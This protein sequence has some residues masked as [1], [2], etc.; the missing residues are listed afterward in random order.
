MAFRN[1]TDIGVPIKILH[2]SEGHII[3]LETIIKDIIEGK[4]EQ[5]EDNM[6]CH[7]STVTI[8]KKNGDVRKMDNLYICGSQIKMVI[9]PEALQ[10]GLFSARFPIFRNKDAVRCMVFLRHGRGK[11]GFYC[12]KG[13]T[14]FF[15]RTQYI[16]VKFVK[17]LHLIFVTHVDEVSK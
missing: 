10:V 8:K 4:L 9:L 3:K 13:L 17:V 11:R 5:A 14:F 2:E 15:K 6:N 1:A 7:M 12:F 16:S